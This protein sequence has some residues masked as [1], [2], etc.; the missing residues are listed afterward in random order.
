MGVGGTDEQG[1]KGGRKRKI[2]ITLKITEKNR[3]I[4]KKTVRNKE[5]RWV[6]RE[7]AIEEKTEKEKEREIMCLSLRRA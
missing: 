4:H 7:T 3:E 2:K 1:G 6:K 5:I